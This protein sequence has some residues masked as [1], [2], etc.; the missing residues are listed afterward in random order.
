MFG[1]PPKP[2]PGFSTESI[3]TLGLTSG[4]TLTIEELAQPLADGIS[5]SFHI[6]IK[7]VQGPSAQTPTVPIQ[8]P[9]RTPPTD[10]P[11]V[12]SNESDTLF[13]RRGTYLFQLR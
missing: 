6:I 4:E 2:L 11:A 3:G 8:L 1:Y 13:I 7:L 9:T 10:S 5:I 12:V